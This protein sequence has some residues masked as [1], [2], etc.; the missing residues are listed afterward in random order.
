MKLKIRMHQP[1]V[2][3]WRLSSSSITRQLLHGNGRL[4]ASIVR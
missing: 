4:H 2:D 1:P 3:A